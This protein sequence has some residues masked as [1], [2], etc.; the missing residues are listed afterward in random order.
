MSD[1]KRR[2]ANERKVVGDPNSTEEGMNKIN[3]RVLVDMEGDSYRLRETLKTNGATFGN[4][5][6]TI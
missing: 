4:V 2:R 1:N 5:K 6:E 3:T